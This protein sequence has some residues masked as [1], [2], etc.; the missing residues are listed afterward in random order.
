[1]SLENRSCTLLMSVSFSFPSLS[2]SV[3]LAFTVTPIS[4]SLSALAAVA[5]IMFAT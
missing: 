1:M 3:P 4:E 5:L 2:I